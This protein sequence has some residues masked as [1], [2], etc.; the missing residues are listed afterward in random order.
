MMA[1]NLGL[2][3]AAAGAAMLGFVFLT[4]EK[5]DPTPPVVTGDKDEE[6]KPPLNK[7]GMVTS[8]DGTTQVI[9]NKTF[10]FNLEAQRCE[11]VCYDNN[12]DAVCISPKG[13]PLPLPTTAEKEKGGFYGVFGWL[14]FGKQ[15]EI[16]KRVDDGAEHQL[17]V[18]SGDPVISHIGITSGLTEYE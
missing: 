1:D 3:V 12:G 5:E 16:P 4:Q 10:Q 6:Y 7:S 9:P 18:F 14:G 8:C 13:T 17:Y 15:Q 11:R 2:I